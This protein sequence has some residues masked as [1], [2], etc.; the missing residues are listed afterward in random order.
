MHLQSVCP[1]RAIVI[2][3]GASHKFRGV[4]S[5]HVILTKE[6]SVSC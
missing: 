1:T 3:S 2:L 5:P 4:Y 6:G